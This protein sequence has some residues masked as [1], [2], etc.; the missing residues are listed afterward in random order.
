MHRGATHNGT[1]ATV[2][3]ARTQP[4]SPAPTTSATRRVQRVDLARCFMPLRLGTSSNGRIVVELHP[5]P[6]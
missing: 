6:R 3:G 1:A 5:A 4:V 2:D